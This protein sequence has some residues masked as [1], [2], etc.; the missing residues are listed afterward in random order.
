MHP[1]ID[2]AKHIERRALPLLGCSDLL[3]LIQHIHSFGHNRT[4]IADACKLAF[5]K[6]SFRP[7]ELRVS[8][9][10]SVQVSSEDVLDLTRADQLLRGY[11]W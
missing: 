11:D 10:L 4:G 5:K 8:K 7:W 6:M 2:F 1:A 9:E 3:F